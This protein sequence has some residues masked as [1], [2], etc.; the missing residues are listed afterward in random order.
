MKGDVDRY[1]RNK[2]R[3]YDHRERR[4]EGHIAKQ[5]HG[6]VNGSR[7]M[8]RLGMLGWDK[9]AEKTN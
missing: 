3:W 6:G 1:E 7:G 4:K 2:M 5:M 9:I 8:G